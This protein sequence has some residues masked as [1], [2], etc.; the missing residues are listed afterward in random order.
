M[1]RTLATALVSVLLALGCSVDDSASSDPGLRAWLRV[2]NAQYES[3]D[4]PAPGAGPAI[5]S[6]RAT[7]NAFRIGTQRERIS[8]TL[9]PDANA[10]AIGRSDDVG[11]W[12]VNAGLPGVDEPDAPSFSTLLGL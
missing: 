9:D 2:A 12:I 10:V 11:F 3:S 5:R 6:L 1:A 8:G 7:H 4:M